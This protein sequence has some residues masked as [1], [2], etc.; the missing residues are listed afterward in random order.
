MER[1]IAS[2][3]DEARPPP[4]PAVDKLVEARYPGVRLESPVQGWVY[5]EEYDR[6]IAAYQDLSAPTS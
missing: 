5:L 2:A 1:A 4:E 3:L 6:G